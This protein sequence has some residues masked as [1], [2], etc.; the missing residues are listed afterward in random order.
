[1]SIL[2]LKNQ[3]IYGIILAVTGLVGWLVFVFF[4]KETKNTNLISS[5]FAGFAAIGILRII[6]SSKLLLNPEKAQDYEAM[7]KDERTKFIANKARAMAF[8]ISILA[9]CIT[10]IIAYFVFDSLL[11]CQLLCYITCFQCLLYYVFWII[12]NK[13]Y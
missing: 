9:Q 2:N 5:F 3:R 10:S 8:Y 12:F 7:Q 13:K 6:Q 11:A 4:V 1:M